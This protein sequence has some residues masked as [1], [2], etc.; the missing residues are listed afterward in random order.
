MVVCIRLKFI[1]RL[2]LHH[3]PSHNNRDRP[4]YVNYYIPIQ[5]HSHTHM[6][7]HVVL[8]KTTNKT[9]MFSIDEDKDMTTHLHALRIF[10]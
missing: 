5:T 4:N 7:I 2:K 6:Y 8:T 3:R 10:C 9:H 1:K